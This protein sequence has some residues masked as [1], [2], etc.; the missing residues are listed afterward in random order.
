MELKMKNPMESNEFKLSDFYQSVILK[1]AGFPLVR[2][3]KQD[4]QHF[5]F[6][7]E[8]SDNQDSDNQAE[9]ILS[10]YWN[11]ELQVDARDLIESINELKTRI[12]SGV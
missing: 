9:L 8:D 7:F 3:E 1:T 4:R 6:V 12:H 10:R 5:V 11:H 2:L